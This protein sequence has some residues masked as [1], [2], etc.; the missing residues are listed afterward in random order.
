MGLLS[1]ERARTTRAGTKKGGPSNRRTGILGMA[2]KKLKPEQLKA[3]QDAVWP[4]KLPNVLVFS[5]ETVRLGDTSKPM[6]VGKARITTQCAGRVPTGKGEIQKDSDKKK[7]KTAGT[8]RVP[9]GMKPD[10]TTTWKCLVGAEKERRGKIL[11][12]DLFRFP[13]RTS[14]CDEPHDPPTTT[15]AQKTQRDETDALTELLHR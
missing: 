11:A 6:N 12:G 13:S 8:I 9:P 1:P 15:G 5:R 3:N 14:P 10:C 7:I 4:S 2:K